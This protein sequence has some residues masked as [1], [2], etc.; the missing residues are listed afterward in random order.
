MNMT[1]PKEPR[2]DRGFG[3]VLG[4]LFGS[5]IYYQ[6][7]GEA[8]LFGLFGVIIAAFLFFLFRYRTIETVASRVSFLLTGV[9]YAGVLITPLALM[10]RRADGAGW[11]YICLTS[12]WLSDTGA[13]FAGRFI[14]KYIPAKLW[15]AI[16]PKKTWVGGV[17]GLLGSVLALS[18]AKL[19][20]LPK[21]SWLDVALIAGP[22]NILGQLGDLAE[23]LIKRSVGVKDSGVLLPGHGGMLDRIDAL[24]F[25]VPYVYVYA[26]LRF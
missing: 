17:G 13:Y 6:S 5:L 20:Y 21:L 24:I 3:V 2:F 12:A 8:V 18:V 1:M 14:G 10:R 22:A 9:L 11:I 25:V 19:W 26:Q 23:S 7:S 4:T 16:S 15:E